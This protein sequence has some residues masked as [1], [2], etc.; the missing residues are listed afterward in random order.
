MNYDEDPSIEQ[1]IQ[2]A[3]HMDIRSSMEKHVTTILVSLITAGIIYVG[4]S[5]TTISGEIRLLKF[6][7][8]VL[9]KEIEGNNRHFV[10]RERFD[11]LEHRVMVLEDKINE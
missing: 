9:N 5:V 10:R 2:E 8:E 1:Y 4:F 6:Q 3:R 7:F 11:T